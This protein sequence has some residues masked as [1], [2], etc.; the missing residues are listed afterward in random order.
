MGGPA[1]CSAS[2]PLGPRRHDPAD[3]EAGSTTLESK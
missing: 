3:A 2:A 1:R